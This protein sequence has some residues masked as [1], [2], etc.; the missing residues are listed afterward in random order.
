MGANEKQFG[1][2]HYRSKSIQ[3]WDYITANNI[4]FLEGNVIK[5]VSRWKDKNGLEDLRKAQHY[6][7]KLIEVETEKLKIEEQNKERINILLNKV[8]VQQELQKQMSE[9]YTEHIQLEQRL[10]QYNN[11]A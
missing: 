6:L 10:E 2:E 3:C 1:G 7:E 5:Y 4:P 8:L 9:S 11:P